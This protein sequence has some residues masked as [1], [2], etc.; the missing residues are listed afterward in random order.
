MPPNSAKPP[1][2]PWRLFWYRILHDPLS[3]NKAARYFNYVLAAIILV[4]CTAVAAETVASIFNPHK[5]LFFVLETASTAVFLIEYCLRIWVCVEN[6]RFTDPIAGRIRY[7]IQPLT[8]LDFLV[9][10][11]YFTPAD[12]R[13]LRIFR[14]TR[15]LRV[16]HLGD[17]DDSL[18]SILAAVGRRKKL[19]VVAMT[20]MLISV[21]CFAAII[22]MVEHQA[23]PA[24]FASIPES[25][26]WA[27]ITLTTIGYGD[28]API[29][30]L[31]KFL[32]SA[33]ALVGIGIFALPTAVVTASILEAGADKKT[34]CRHC[35]KDPHQ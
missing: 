2:I 8:V 29:T 22:Y 15:L 20:A 24:K 23:Q 13:F 6:P 11:T 35:G 30:P 1:I 7:A 16:L 4:N 21:Y 27:V 33:I 31:G 10:V 17:F 12:F 3:S 9:I 26:W 28:M 25:L 19:L 34:V 5:E 18:N 14:L 32:A